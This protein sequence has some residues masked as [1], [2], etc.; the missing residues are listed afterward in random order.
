MISASVRILGICAFIGAMIPTLAQSETWRE[1]TSADGRKLEALLIS[2]AADS[3]TVKRKLDLKELTI[4]LSSLSE[5]DQAHAAALLE[6][7]MEA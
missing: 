5:A 3:V 6:Q 1:W 7:Q 2:V 4:P